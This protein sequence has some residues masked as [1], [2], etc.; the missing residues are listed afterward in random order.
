[1]RK[2]KYFEII[3]LHHHGAQNIE[4]GKQPASPTALLITDS[5]YI[6]FIG[7]EMLL[8]CPGGF[9]NRKGLDAIV[10]QSI[11]PRHVALV[12]IEYF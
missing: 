12:C 11:L 8:P 6:N 2:F 3:F 7:E 4:S 5:F 1:M 9:V 10:R